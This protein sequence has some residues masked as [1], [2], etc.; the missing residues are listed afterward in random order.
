[1]ANTPRETPITRDWWDQELQS[2]GTLYEELA[3]VPRLSGLQEVRRVDGLVVLD[4][5]SGRRCRRRG[6]LDL[7]S[8]AIVV[9]QTKAMPLNAYVFGQAL[10]SP[11]LIRQS[12]NPKDIRTVLLCLAD[13]PEL[14]GVISRSF[15]E[16][17]IRV[18][19]GQRSSFSL[20]RIPGAAGSYVGSQG[21]SFRGQERL[22]AGLTI[23]GAI[24]PGLDTHDRRPLT[25]VACGKDITTIHSQMSNRN[26]PAR[27]GMWMGGEII[28]S[29]RILLEAGARTVRSVVLCGHHDQAIE[30]AIRNYADFKVIP[31]QAAVL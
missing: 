20:R 3:I 5:P 6:M 4:D 29:Q 30:E 9:I 21:A 1:M 31:V 10:L 11:Q 16:V 2:A 28:M 24:V 14:S 22:A 7:D 25:Q 26:V 17:E 13:Q 23:D 15:P 19:P 18:R 12:W 8:R 27:I